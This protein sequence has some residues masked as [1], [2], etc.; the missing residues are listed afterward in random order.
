M[1]TTNW[2]LIATISRALT[3][4]SLGQNSNKLCKSFVVFDLNDL[5]LEAAWLKSFFQL[6]VLFDFHPSMLS[7]VRF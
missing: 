5:S 1:C 7:I 3:C 6:V 2:S 4:T